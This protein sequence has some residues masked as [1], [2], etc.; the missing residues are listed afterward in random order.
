M[1]VTHEPRGDRT[2]AMADALG[3]LRKSPNDSLQI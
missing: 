3:N 2:Q 1:Q